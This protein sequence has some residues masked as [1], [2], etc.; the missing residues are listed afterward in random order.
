LDW[1]QAVDIYCERTSTALWAEPVNAASNAA[2]ILAALWAAF[3]ARKR[4][5]TQ[6]ILW[7]LI[8]M[9]ALIGAGQSGAL[10]ACSC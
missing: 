2:F 8:T 3:E 6:P 5:L 10:S 1:F 9:A 7:L 4:G